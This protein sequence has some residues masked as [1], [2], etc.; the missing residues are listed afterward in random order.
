MKFKSKAMK[1]LHLTLKRTKGH[2]RKFLLTFA[3]VNVQSYF[4]SHADF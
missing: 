1:L 2:P 4:F 3:I